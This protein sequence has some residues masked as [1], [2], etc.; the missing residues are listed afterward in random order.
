MTY[1]EF[2]AILIQRNF[3]MHRTQRQEKK[4]R[5]EE[6]ELRRRQEEEAALAAAKLAEAVENGL[7]TAEITATT[8]DGQTGKPNEASGG[9]ALTSASSKSSDGINENAFASCIQDAWRK[10]CVR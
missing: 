4:R 10:Y 1:L 9:G 3:R 2:S 7:E 8:V 6:A 5:E